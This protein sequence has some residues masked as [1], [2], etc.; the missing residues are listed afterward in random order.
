MEVLLE[1]TAQQQRKWGKV[2]PAW[3]GPYTISR[4]IG[5]GLYEL[6]N[7]QGEVLKKANINWLTLFKRRE[8]KSSSEKP[9]TTSE[10][11]KS[12]SE[13]PETTSEKPVLPPSKAT[14]KWHLTANSCNKSKKCVI[15]VSSDT[16]SGEDGESNDQAWV[17]IG[18]VTLMRDH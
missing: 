5:K 17:K 10:K 4:C 1:N 6:K 12:T 14:R 9:E 7:S 13:K 11:P 15:V 16:E 8:L 2:G 18:D 3:M